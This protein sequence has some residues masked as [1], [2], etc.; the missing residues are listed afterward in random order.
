MPVRRTLEKTMHNAC[1]SATC[2]Y[3]MRQL[4]TLVLVAVANP[5]I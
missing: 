4:R 1:I 2:E 5:R 3:S